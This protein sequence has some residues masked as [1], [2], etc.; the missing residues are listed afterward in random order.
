MR[1]KPEWLEDAGTACSFALI[2][3]AFGEYDT[4]KH[5][6]VILGGLDSPLSQ[7]CGEPPLPSAI[8]THLLLQERHDDGRQN[9]D[10]HGQ[11]D[12]GE[13]RLQQGLRRH[14]GQLLQIH[15]LPSCRK[16]GGSEWGRETA[17]LARPTKEPGGGLGWVTLTPRGPE[18]A[19]ST[20]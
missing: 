7:P 10:G 2:E 6:S 19:M 18:A 8:C 14:G 1:R 9:Q 17:S 13:R 15:C 5:P 16:Q 3:Q 12:S 4:P 11:D 20:L